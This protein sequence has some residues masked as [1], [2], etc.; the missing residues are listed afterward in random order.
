[1]AELNGFSGLIQLSSYVHLML[2]SAPSDR[3]SVPKSFR[4]LKV[5]TWGHAMHINQDIFFPGDLS[6]TEF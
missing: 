1:M 6:R 5:N 4:A 3:Y 2:G